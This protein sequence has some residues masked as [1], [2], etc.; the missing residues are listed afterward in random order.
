[1]SDV[2]LLSPTKLHSV[3]LFA[4]IVCHLCSP[5]LLT[6][7]LHNGSFLSEFD[8]A[9]NNNSQP[10][11]KIDE[12]ELRKRLSPEAV[13]VLLHAGTERPFTGKYTD[14][15]AEGNYKCAACGSL[16][17]RS[18][19]KFHSGCGWPAFHSQVSPEA[20]VSREDK[21][22]GMR[23]VEVLCANC[24]GHLGHVFDE[25]HWG[26]LA[27]TGKRYCINS[28][29]LDFEAKPSSSSSS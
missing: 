13:N 26:K 3:V 12:S 6:V 28:V 4:N 10:R 19:D 7:Y 25:A 29:S 18:A 9:T 20:V 5:L 21:T 11:I 8:M 14:T 22:H 15:D 17:F 27:P 16:L 24:G 1:V 23:R 2:Q